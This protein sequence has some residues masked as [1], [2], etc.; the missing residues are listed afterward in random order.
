MFCARNLLIC[1]PHDADQAPLLAPTSRTMPRLP[2][3]AASRAANMA[4]A[5]PCSKDA[6]FIE[7]AGMASAACGTSLADEK[8]A[9]IQSAR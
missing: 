8:S 3:G 5:A 4:A 9:A 7:P 2:A 1:E 6:G